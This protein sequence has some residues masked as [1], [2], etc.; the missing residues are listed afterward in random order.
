MHRCFY[1][2]HR[3]EADFSEVVRAILLPQSHHSLEYVLKQH[4]ILTEIMYPVTAISPK[5]TC[6]IVYSLGTFVYRLILP[7]LYQGF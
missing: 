5:N 7:G 1:E 3:Q 6:S 4:N 2:R